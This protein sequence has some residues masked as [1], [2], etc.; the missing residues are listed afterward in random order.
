MRRI[1]IPL[2]FGIA[3]AL[4]LVSLGI[5]QVNRLAWKQGELARIEA[6]IAAD[7]VPLPAA[8]EAKRDQYLPVTMEGQFAPGVLRVLVSRKQVGAGYRIIS[9]FETNGRMVLVDRGFVRVETPLAPPPPGVVTL[10]GNLNWPDDRN[11][12]TPENDLE[13]N[14]WFARD[15]AQMS[16]LLKTEP[17]LVIARS[18]SQPDD[19]MTVM[20][21]DTSGIPNDHLHY[22]ITWFSLAAIWL[23]MTGYFIWRT[24]RTTKGKDA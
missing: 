7:P 12:S 22:A 6:K 3:G 9:P 4:V 14:I 2:I 11:G 5:W 15:I 8:P 13:A 18:V 24:G 17:L 19:P 1:I 10:T 21:V 23:A 16:G 20:P